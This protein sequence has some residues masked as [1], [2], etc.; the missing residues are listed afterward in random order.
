MSPA[1][2]ADLGAGSFFD[3]E[4]LTKYA[5]RTEGG[6]CV[7][8]RGNRRGSR[9]HSAAV[10]KTTKITLGL[11]VNTWSFVPQTSSCVHILDVK[12]KLLWNSI[13]YIVDPLFLVESPRCLV[14]FLLFNW[15][16]CIVF[17]IQLIR[18]KAHTC[19]EIH[20]LFGTQWP[21]RFVFKVLPIT[22]YRFCILQPRL[23]STKLINKWTLY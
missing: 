3:R 15:I 11:R 2:F 7:V 5:Y 17:V 4:Y 21:G 9:V 1:V 8:G 6:T 22:T 18:T 23:R 19:Q 10:E 14:A 20:A 12:C 16:S 13:L